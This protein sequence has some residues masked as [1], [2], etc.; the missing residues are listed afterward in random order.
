MKEKDCFY[1]KLYKL[2]LQVGKSSSLLG[3]LKEAAKKAGVKPIKLHALR[4]SHVAFLC[5]GLTLAMFI[6][7][8]LCGLNFFC[9]HKGLKK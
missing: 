6:S 2:L 5:L 8:L 3:W 1:D 4:H 9:T 7:S